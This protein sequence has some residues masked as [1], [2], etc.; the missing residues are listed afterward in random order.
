[1]HCLLFITDNITK[2]IHFIK[3]SDIIKNKRIAYDWSDKLDLSKDKEPEL[4]FKFGKY[5]QTNYLKYKEDEDVELGLGD[6]SFI[7]DDKMLPIEKTLIEMPF[8]ATE[9]REGFCLGGINCAIIKCQE[10]NKVHILDLDDGLMYHSIDGLHWI[11]TELENIDS[12]TWFYQGEDDNGSSGVNAKFDEPIIIKD[13]SPRILAVEKVSDVGDDIK[14]YE[15]KKE[16]FTG[17]DDNINIAYFI[18]P[19]YGDISFN[20]LIDDHYQEFINTMNKPKVLT[21]YF[22]LSPIDIL[23]FDF[24][25]PVWID[26]YQS[27][28]YV[29]KIEEYQ[30]EITKVVLIKI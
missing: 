30:G 28:F 7:F 12:F 22:K 13:S 3:F 25:I 27:Y 19:E 21:A 15:G 10:I 20:G 4:K 18:H 26:H 5:G 23:Q 6:D 1:M 14:F 29:N 17:K 8:A 11:L 9:S 2:T 16:D 24:T